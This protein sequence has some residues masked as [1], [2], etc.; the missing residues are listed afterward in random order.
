M[1]ANSPEERLAQAGLALPP[2]PQPRGN[3]APFHLHPLRGGDYQLTFSGQTCRV[4]GVA[5]AG[6]CTPAESIEPAREA[7][8]TAML[9][10]L[11][12]VSVACDGALPAR[13]VVTRL[14]GF[15]RSSVEFTAHTRVLD[16][17]SEMLTIAWPEVARPARTAVGVSSLPDGAFIEIEMDAIL[18][19]DD[20]SE[21]RSTAPG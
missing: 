20:Q 4:N 21:C 3:Y 10:L 9:N 13:L 11:A 18:P 7:A 19:F 5:I 6:M 8:K 17:A 14:R 16:A 15:I 12:A 2:P 1:N